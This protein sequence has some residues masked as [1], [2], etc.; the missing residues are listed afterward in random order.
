DVA[1]VDE[2][3]YYYL[4]ARK[5]EILKVAGKR[6]SPKEIEEVILSVPE[7]IDCTI[8]G[9]DD[10]LFG[11]A[12]QATIVANTPFDEEELKEKILHACSKKLALYKMPQKVFFEK[13]MKMSATGKKIK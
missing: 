8:S 2:D 3:G 13:A 1:I 5:K 6:V 10:E 4:M 11:E 7:V 12:I 9:Y